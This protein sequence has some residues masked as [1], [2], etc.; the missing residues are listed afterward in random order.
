MD[1][2]GVRGGPDP[3]VSPLARFLAAPARV[4][5]AARADLAELRAAWADC[6]VE[7]APAPGVQVGRLRRFLVPV[8]ERSYDG[9]AARIADLEQLEQAAARFADRGRMVAE[10]TLDPPRSTSDLAGPPMLDDDW[11]V[12]ST[13][14]SAKGGEWD[15]VHVI[16][17]AD[18]MFPSDMA[19]GDA[20]GIEE[21]RRLFYVAVTRARDVLEINAPHRYH[22]RRTGRD[23]AHSYGQ[24]SR[25][26]SPSVRA[27][28]DEEWRAPEPGRDEV[29]FAGGSGRPGGMAAVDGLLAD[30]WH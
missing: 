26:L 10:L 19:T 18:G 20:E 13:V 21:E 27:L 11:L 17:A 25:F 6:A 22:H 28:L 5:A 9:A 7:P 12:L 23:D 30:L 1:A 14:H 29:S 4:P 2:A 15:V 3:L 24:L 16:H 8:V